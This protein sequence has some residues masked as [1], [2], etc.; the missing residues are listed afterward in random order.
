MFSKIFNPRNS[1]I[2]AVG[3][4]V[5]LSAV[6]YQ[7]GRGSS[8]A[9]DVSL[10]SATPVTTPQ[11]STP[12]IATT[13]TA[14]DSSQPSSPVSSATQEDKVG[15]SIAGGSSTS[16]VRSTSSSS[17]VNSAPTRNYQDE[18]PVTTPVTT[19]VPPVTVPP[20]H[21][22]DRSAYVET[23]ESEQNDDLASWRLKNFR[24]LALTS[25]EDHTPSP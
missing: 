17:S 3:V 2:L 20:K 9:F 24:V 21:H 14:A 19:P 22:D 12:N 4:I 8:S 11:K 15:S 6:G 5:S 18:T 23:N 13:K 7:V 1:W 25:P 16:S 10:K